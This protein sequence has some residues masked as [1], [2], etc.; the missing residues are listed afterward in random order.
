MQ[1]AIKEAEE[2]VSNNQEDSDV[3]VKE[4]PTSKVEILAGAGIVPEGEFEVESKEQKQAQGKQKSD[5]P[6]GEDRIID[7]TKTQVVEK[8][9]SVGAEANVE[10][11]ES[12]EKATTAEA[13]E[14]ADN[15]SINTETR[16]E[17]KA[18]NIEAKIEEAVEVEKEADEAAETEAKVEDEAT[19]TEANVEEPAT[20]T[21]AK[22]EEKVAA[23]AE[24]EPKEA[25]EN[26]KTENKKT[27]KKEDQTMDN[28]IVRENVL[29]EAE[30]TEFKNYLNVEGF[31]INIREVLQ[32]LIVNYSPNGK[33]EHGNVIIMGNEK[34][35][36]TTLAIELIK[37]VNR[38]RGRRNRKLA[39]V[40]ARVLNRKGFKY[41]L[42]KLVGS[43]LIIENADQLGKMT[44]I[45]LL[46]GCGMFTDDMLIILEGNEDGMEE[47]LKENPK[48]ETTFNHIVRIKEYNIE[49]WVEYGKRYALNKGYE[50]DEL[51]NLAFYKA[52][53]DY[54][55]ANKGISQDNVEEIIDNAI[56]HT[57]KLG[58]KFKGIFGSKSKNDGL[59]LLQES[60]F[61]I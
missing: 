24:A 6:V 36:K 54:F 55:G 56:A 57:K 40:D 26:K 12:E 8:K 28:N 39:K 16:T 37:L 1:K 5:T 38:K 43:D 47:L 19:E 20:A 52:I 2:V 25:T 9:I 18:D 22:T 13:E 61:E 41:V 11:V 59:N 60:D 53:D 48:L 7:T 32:E 49:E 45:S 50:M 23:T 21:E 14:K 31:E 4:N 33:S 17:E 35:G 44:V 51:A 58:R 15:K 3:R 46:D 30:L 29:S 34:T 10:S 42:G 27:E